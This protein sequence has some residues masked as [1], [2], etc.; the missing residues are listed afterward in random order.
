MVGDPGNPEVPARAAYNRF[1]VSD[2]GTGTAV[3]TLSRQT[4]CPAGAHLPGE[5]VV[6]IGILGRGEDKQPAILRQTASDTQYVPACG[7]RT[8]V[9]PTPSAP[10]RVEVAIQT[11]VPSQVD[12]KGSAGERRALGARVSFDVVPR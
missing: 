1:D 2:G 11:F 5:A 10:W 8:F 9:L 6:R 3:V 12:P 7:F 4:F